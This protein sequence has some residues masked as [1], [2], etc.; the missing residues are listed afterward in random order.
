MSDWSSARCR[1]CR[2]AADRS[3]RLHPERPPASSPAAVRAFA[4]RSM[5]RRATC[6]RGILRA[7]AV[8]VDT[9]RAC[10]DSVSCAHDSKTIRTMR[11]SQR[12]PDH[13]RGRRGRS[14]DRR[15]DGTAAA[16][17]AL[18]RRMSRAGA[19]RAHRPAP[20]HAAEGRATR[21]R[22]ADRPPPVSFLPAGTATGAATRDTG[23]ARRRLSHD[24][25][26]PIPAP[27]R[28]TPPSRP[29]PQRNTEILTR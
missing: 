9:H 7:V 10:A 28:R 20:G 16:A 14:M 3:R 13:V 18:H 26:C 11:G 25:P 24:R 4:A 12:S 15:Q 8:F 6:A 23:S 2:R 27:R 19:G 21:L 5:R 17:T 22:A 29:G 1:P